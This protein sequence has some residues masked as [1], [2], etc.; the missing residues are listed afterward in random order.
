MTERIIVTGG[1]R[2]SLYDRMQELMIGNRIDGGFHVSH[3]EGARYVVL[4]EL[5]DAEDKLFK[6]LFYPIQPRGKKWLEPFKVTSVGKMVMGKLIWKGKNNWNMKRIKN[7]WRENEWRE[8][9]IALGDR[10]ID[11][12]RLKR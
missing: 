3:W 4:D 12:D 2:M 9:K 1:R 6:P 5:T 10:V 7:E 8:K 11:L